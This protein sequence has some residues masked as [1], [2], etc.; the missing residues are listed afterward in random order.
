[1]MICTPAWLAWP[2]TQTLMRAFE[3]HSDQVRFVGG[4]VR[5]AL[6]DKT[7]QDIDLA[8]SLKPEQAMG[9]P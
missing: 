3:K 9:V 1:M 6:L 5:D 4:A 2:E 7:V 8:T